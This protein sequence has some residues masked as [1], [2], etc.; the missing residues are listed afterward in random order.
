MLKAF[1][2]A[3]FVLG[4]SYQEVHYFVMSFVHLLAAHPT[5]VTKIIFIKPYIQSTLR[6]KQKLFQDILSP[7]CRFEIDIFFFIMFLLLRI[8]YF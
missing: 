6:S 5:D 1:Y 7:Y 3:L 8:L 2:V 4:Q